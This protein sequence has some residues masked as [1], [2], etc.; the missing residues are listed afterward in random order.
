MDCECNS[1]RPAIVPTYKLQEVCMYK[2]KSPG[3]ECEAL[4]IYCNTDSYVSQR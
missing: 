1:Y 4:G 2:K 3:L